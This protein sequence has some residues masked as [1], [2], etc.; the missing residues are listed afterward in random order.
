MNALILLAQAFFNHQ[1]QLQSTRLKEAGHRAAETGRRIAIAGIF[2]ALA[3]ALIFAALLISVIDI[4]LQIDRSHGVSF[5]GLMIS[6]M[7]LIVIALF[8]IFSGWISSRDTKTETHESVPEAPRSELR[9]LLEAVAIGMLKEFLE[10]QNR[11]HAENAK[12]SG[13]GASRKEAQ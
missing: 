12:T 3:S 5:S 11:K 2:Y 1:T 8:S 9:P 10:H 13:D 4:G 6:S 7:L